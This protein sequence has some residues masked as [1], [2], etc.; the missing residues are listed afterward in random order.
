MQPDEQIR[1]KENRSQKHAS[2]FELF[3]YEQVGSRY[4]LRFTRFAL[5]LI[6]GLTFLSIIM[7]FV[8]F[9]LSDNHDAT[10]DV[11]VN[12]TI[13]P[14]PSPYLPEYTLIRQ[15][16]PPALPPKVAKQPDHKMPAPPRPVVINSNTHER[17]R[18][19]Q[20]PTPLSTPK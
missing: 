4:Y 16:P 5:V 12:L 18:P 10:K 1:L 19:E 20:T 9:L 7:I 6:V 11:N 3:F 15:A 14:S 8:L 17:P 13:L 2:S